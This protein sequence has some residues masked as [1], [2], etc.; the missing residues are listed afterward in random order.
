MHSIHL[1]HLRHINSL[2]KELNHWLGFP[3]TLAESIH[4]STTSFL[5]S[6]TASDFTSIVFSD[7]RPGHNGQHSRSFS[8]YYSWLVTKHTHMT[9]LY[10]FLSRISAK[11]SQTMY[12][13]IFIYVIFIKQVSIILKSHFFL[14]VKIF[15]LSCRSSV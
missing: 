1:F 10:V 3:V 6:T 5:P 14:N 12:T 2:K 13:K 15:T 11:M 7:G 4:F 8:C 9:L